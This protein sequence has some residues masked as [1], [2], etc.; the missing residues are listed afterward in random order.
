MAWY[1]PIL[2]FLA[3][4]C[5][6]SI[7]TFR[8]M[9]VISGHRYISAGLGFVEVVIWTLAVGGAL[10]YLGESVL[11]LVA[12]A[13]GFAAGVYVGMFL[14]D[15]I[16]LGYRA[17]RIIANG[18]HVDLAGKLREHGYRVT[19]VDGSGRDGP[20]E[21]AFCVIRR[22][23]LAEVRELIARFAPSSYVTVERVDPLPHVIRGTDTRFARRLVDRT[24]L[25]RK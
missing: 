14:E 20:V 15:R 10:T 12:Y 4:I 6:V 16:A 17:L 24:E 3:R 22:K 2:I 18:S 8:T 7:G 1:I 21:I 11:A 19:R 5:D 9:L 25:I 23:R 13:G